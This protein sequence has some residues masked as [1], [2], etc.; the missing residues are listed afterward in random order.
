MTG[1]ELD[2]GMVAKARE[3]ELLTADKMGLYDV[4]DLKECW[5]R[6]GK[7]PIS[8]RWIDIN[9]GDEQNPIMRSRWVARQFRDGDLDG[10][11]AAKRRGN[12]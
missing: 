6:T 5:Q 12:L 7:P 10:C 11:F 4:V 8:T 2:P 1:V 9:K 3:E